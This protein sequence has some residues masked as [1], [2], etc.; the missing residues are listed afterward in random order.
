MR[1]RP[2]TLLSCCVSLDGYLD[3]AGRDR[4]VLSPAADLDRVDAERA[5]CDAILVGAETVRRD[6][7]RLLVRSDGCRAARLSRGL[8]ATP[9]R[10]TVTR[11]GDL[12]PG[13]RIFT[14]PGAGTLVYAA[15]SAAGPLTEQLGHTA[16]VVNAGPDGD[17]SWILDDLYAR[18]V[19]RLMVEGGRR[20][21]TQLLAAD[22][23]DELQLVVAPVFVGDPRAPRFVDPG[24]Y[25]FRAPHRAR[26][27][28]VRQVGDAALLRYALTDRSP[29]PS[30]EP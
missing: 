7:P 30:E 4:L 9:L 18:G 2:Y 16:T 21:L 5:G 14:E 26:L 6:D 29:V 25:P 10:V 17:L 11:S 27:A 20:V 3:D 19:R 28:E 22:L 15:S 23:A 1:D 13:A 8:P 24:E 12:D